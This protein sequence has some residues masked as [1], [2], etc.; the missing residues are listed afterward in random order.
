LLLRQY[1]LKRITVFVSH[2]GKVRV[3]RLAFLIVRYRTRMIDEVPNI[4]QNECP[5]QAGHFSHFNLGSWVV[6]VVAPDPRD[7]G[8]ARDTFPPYRTTERDRMVEQQ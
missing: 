8:I 3:R 1:A 4:F 5:P 7:N 2:V 6:K